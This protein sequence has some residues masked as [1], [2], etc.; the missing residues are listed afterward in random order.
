MRKS[1]RIAS[2]VLAA[3]LFFSY[4]SL[5]AQVKIG[6][7]PAAIDP[8]AILELESTRK[9]LLLPRVDDAGMAAISASL[10]SGFLVYYTG[11]GPAGVA[12]LF[13]KVGANMVRLSTETGA[14]VPWKQDGNIGTALSFVGTTNNFPLVLKANNLDGLT[15]GIDG[16]LQFGIQPDAAPAA[17]NEILIIAPDGK[18]Q[19]R[20]LALSSVTEL[21]GQKGD[22]VIELAES[23]AATDF[24]ITTTAPVPGTPGKITLT[25]PTQAGQATY[26]LM[27]SDDYT[28]LQDLLAADGFEVKTPFNATGGL[29][30]GALFEKRPSTNKWDL[31]L[32]PATET[33]PGIVS[34]EA[35]TFVGDKTFVAATTT[36]DVANVVIRKTAVTGGAGPANLEVEGNVKF[37][38]LSTQTLVSGDTYNVLLKNATSDSVKTV[39]VPGWKL[40]STGIGQITTTSPTPATG[41][42]TGDLAFEATKTGNDFTVTSDADKITF[43][44]PDASEVAGR[45]G[46]V[47]AAAQTFGGDKTF[48]NKVLVGPAATAVSTGS[49]LNINGSVGVKFRTVLAGSPIGPDDYII[50]TAATSPTSGLTLPDAI[51]AKGRIYVIKRIP[52]SNPAT[53]EDNNLVI[54][55]TSSQT[56][57]GVASTSITVVH[58]SITLMSDGINWQLLSRGTG[59]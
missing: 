11:G 19:K 38:G 41:N 37:P 21:N 35:Q 55:T 17:N 29:A 10:N 22:L 45:R 31:T 24:A 46:L 47:T 14:G 57:N 28:K 4:D 39:G 15:I 44:L 23:D 42:G 13:V 16:K 30:A 18:I 3:L 58:T 7:N 6:G 1:L 9:G 8:A 2:M 56:I 40:T 26:G 54:S 12:G 53:E 20:D 43:D 59:F 36:L 49:N 5:K 32:A 48:E 51:A 25:I 34:I 52:G 27:H 50:L 33:T